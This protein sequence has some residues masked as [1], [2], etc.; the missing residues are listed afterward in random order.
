MSRRLA[1][2]IYV[3]IELCRGEV[4]TVNRKAAALNIKQRTNSSS[5]NHT[6]E[7]ICKSVFKKG[8]FGHV[9]YFKNNEVCQKLLAHL[10]RLGA[11][12]RSGGIAVRPSRNRYLAS[13]VLPSIFRSGT[14][15]RARPRSHRTF[16]AAQCDMKGLEAR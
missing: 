13:N 10:K 8:V 9:L 1:S 11:H 5:S 16:C 14:M 6:T 15:R 7:T 3:D 4:R 2:H 12:S